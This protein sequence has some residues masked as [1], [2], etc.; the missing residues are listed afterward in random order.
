MRAVRDTVQGCQRLPDRLLRP[1]GALGGLNLAGP[2]ESSSGQGIR[3]GEIEEYWILIFYGR[4][5]EPGISLG[6]GSGFPL[7]HAPLQ[8][9]TR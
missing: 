8:S 6:S 4:A 1:Q 7:L 3:R 5:P 9:L 2:P